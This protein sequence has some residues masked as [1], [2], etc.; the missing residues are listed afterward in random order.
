MPIIESL[1]EKAPPRPPLR[2][3]PAHSPEARGLATLD[4]LNPA[5]RYLSTL[6]APSRRSMR[7][8]LARV[9][10][11]LKCPFERV[12]WAELR[13]PHLERLRAVMQ[14]ARL[15]PSTVNATLAALRGVARQAFHL[16]ALD[17]ADYQLVL[18][19]RG[20]RGTRAG[21]AGRALDACEVGQLLD[22][23]ARDTT[24]AGARDAALVA[25]LAGAG[26]RRAEAVALTLDDWRA[27]THALRVRGKGDRERLVYFE[28]GGA[29]RALLAWLK[30]RGEEPGALLTP[31][32]RRGLV[33]VR[34]MTAQAVY[35]ALRKRGREAGIRRKFSPH[36]LRR[37]FATHLLARGAD[38]RGVSEF[39]GHASV[40]TMA[41]YDRRGEQ[42]KRQVARLISLPYSGGG[43]GKKRRRRRRRRA[44]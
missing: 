15:S 41:H 7:A 26:L 42:A 30:A 8:N 44:K 11:L 14:D 28:D 24:A 43:R 21:S 31:V 33:E 35:N 2:L 1:P 34:P 4:A 16:R 38:V 32:D 40:E 23:C 3:V 9:A 5:L 18:E 13:A 39:L 37:F 25:L 6:A 22:A 29:R 12:P 19:V 36:S 20:V 10:R 27:R 17:A